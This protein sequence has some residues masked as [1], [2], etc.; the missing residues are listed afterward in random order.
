MCQLARGIIPSYFQYLGM[1]V[2]ETRSGGILT[3]R[4]RVPRQCITEGGLGGKDRT[5]GCVMCQ[6]KVSWGGARLYR[7]LSRHHGAQVEGVEGLVCPV[8]EVVTREG[9]VTA[10]RT[11]LQDLADGIVLLEKE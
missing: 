8:P 5:L 7:G 9:G 4:D 6:G 3:Q 1:A 11:R 10:P 2:K